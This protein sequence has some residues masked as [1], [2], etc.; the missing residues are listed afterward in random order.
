MVCTA[1]YKVLMIKYIRFK[2]VARRISE[3]NFSFENFLE[4]SLGISLKL[5]L[6][7]TCWKVDVGLE[8]RV[9]DRNT[10]TVKQKT[11]GKLLVRNYTQV[12]SFR[13]RN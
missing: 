10:S 8:N 5:C 4:T 11:V 6:F 1:L 3:S 9:S 13:P 2:L 12:S 7:V